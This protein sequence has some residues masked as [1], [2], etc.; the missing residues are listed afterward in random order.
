MD[1]VIVDTDVVS[2]TFKRDTRHHLYRPHLAGK[3][4]YLSFMTMAELDLW[5]KAHNWGERRR[6]ELDAFLQP[7]TVIE[8]D[9]ELCRQWAA[10]K[11]QVQRSGYHIETADAWIAATALLYSVPL[12]T[13][14]RNHFIHVNGLN[15]ISESPR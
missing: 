7:Y 4:L 10:L 15:V 5:A 12:V 9:R 1:F 2:F 13:H 3:L 6:A 8:S 11:H 14:N